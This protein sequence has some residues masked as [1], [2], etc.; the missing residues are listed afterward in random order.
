MPILKPVSS[1]FMAPHKASVFF[2]INLLVKQSKSS[3]NQF[4]SFTYCIKYLK[5]KIRLLQPHPFLKTACSYLRMLFSTISLLFGKTK[6]KT[7]NAIDGTVVP[8]LFATVTKT[9]LSVPRSCCLLLFIPCSIFCFSFPF[10][11]IKRL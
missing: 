10:I 3:E 11:Q 2:F 6:Q 5:T 7:S 4:I 8:L 1:T 9:S